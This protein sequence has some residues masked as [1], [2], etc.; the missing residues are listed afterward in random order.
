MSDLEW[1]ENLERVQMMAEGNPKWDLSPND[2]AALKAVLDH[3]DAL[4]NSVYYGIG[5]PF[6]R[7]ERDYRRA[8]NGRDPVST[9]QFVLWLIHR[10]ETAEA[11]RGQE[12]R[13]F[14][15]TVPPH[16]G[17]WADLVG[18][19]PGMSPNAPLVVMLRGLA[20]LWRGHPVGNPCATCGDAGVVCC[21]K[22][23][24]TDQMPFGVGP[25]KV[26]PDCAGK[27]KK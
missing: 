3:I 8:H 9:E 11:E 14:E 10:Y 22:E 4:S 15:E 20:Q 1:Q 16:V 18:L 5:L 27:G 19:E 26:C 17:E 2:R 24:A 25:V 23:E 6:D 21:S 7:A 13:K 12:R